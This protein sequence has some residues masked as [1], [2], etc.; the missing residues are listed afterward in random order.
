VVALAQATTSIDTTLD[1]LADDGH[2]LVSQP[3]QGMEPCRPP[4]CT[5]AEPATT[6]TTT[7][8]PSTLPP[9]GTQPADPAAA[10]ADIERAFGDAYTAKPAAVKTAAIED[11][12]QLT[13]V[14]GTFM[15]GPFAD[16]ARQAHAR[17]DTIVFE[18]PTRAAVRYDILAP[19]ADHLGRTGGAVLAGGRWKVARSTF[20]TD[21]ALGGV[22][23][24]R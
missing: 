22:N 10:R 17:I 1:A 19:G 18:S 20:C 7:P 2:V 8:T 21:L 15:S 24:P 5:F 14:V 13:G 4:S 3:V 23:C 6:T 16:I 11:G 12:D 9:A